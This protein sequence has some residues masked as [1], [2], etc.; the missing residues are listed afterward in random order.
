MTWI[1][2]YGEFQLS[3]GVQIS[4]TPKIFEEPQNYL[5][6]SSYTT[7]PQSLDHKDYFW[8]LENFKDHPHCF[9][10]MYISQL[11]VSCKFNKKFWMTENRKVLF[12]DNA[13]YYQLLQL[14][15]IKIML[16]S[17]RITVTHSVD[18]RVIY[19]FK[20]CHRKCQLQPLVTKMEESSVHQ[21][22]KS[23]HESSGLDKHSI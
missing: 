21:L 16:P 12:L 8:S 23:I 4:F 7:H 17:N 10:N 9:K 14:S 20:S 15:T 2:S 13:T 22:S 6:D 19:M 11:P 5:R 3:P 1:H 18:Q